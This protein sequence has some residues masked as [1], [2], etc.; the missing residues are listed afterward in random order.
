MPLGYNKGYVHDMSRD[1]MLP[2]EP[3]FYTFV[4]GSFTTSASTCVLRIVAKGHL[5][6]V[7]KV[8]FTTDIS[9]RVLRIVVKGHFDK[10]E[11]QR[12]KSL[13]ILVTPSLRPDG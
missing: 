13:L 6:K 5:P 10:I 1:I 7:L 9:T 4:G 2:K 8:S 11:E 12:F 3:S